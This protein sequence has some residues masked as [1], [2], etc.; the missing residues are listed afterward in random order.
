MALYAIG[1]VQGCDAEL[2]QLLNASASPPT[3]TGCGSSAIWSIAVPTPPA[4]CAGFARSAPPRRSRSAITICTCWRWRAAAR[5]CAATTR[6]M[7]YLAAPDRECA[8]RLARCTAADA[9][10]ARAQLCLLHAGLPPQWDIA[11]ARGC[12]REFEAA[13]RPI[14]PRC[15]TGCTAIEPDLWDESLARRGAPAL[16]SSIASR[17]CATWIAQGRLKLRFK[18]APKKARREAL[19]SVV[20]RAECPL[21]RHANRVRPLVDPGVFQNSDVVGLDSGCVWGGSLTALRLDPPG[22]EPVHIPCPSI[23]RRARPAASILRRAR[24]AHA[25]LALER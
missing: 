7:R 13:L 8:A 15:S 17:A 23:S 22:G 20:C 12:A 18:G 16:S 6:S 1:D 10:G 24:P 11:T 3:A 5:A 19:I 21:A 14:R 4:C 25:G 9:R 2:G